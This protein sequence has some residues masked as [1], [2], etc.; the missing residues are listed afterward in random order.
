MN[1]PN[2]S[3]IQKVF[4][5][6]SACRYTCVTK[7]SLYFVAKKGFKNRNVLDTDSIN[8]N[9]LDIYEIC[10]MYTLY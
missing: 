2:D 9:I 8:N 6:P 10:F 7:N 3:P 4:Y 5:Y 1:V